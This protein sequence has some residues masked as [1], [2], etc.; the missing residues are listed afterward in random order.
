MKWM[1]LKPI[2]QGEESQNEKDKYHV[3]MHP[4]GIQKD[5]DEEP[6]CRAANET[7]T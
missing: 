2:A 7:Q 6:I 3:L 4:Y 5:D 1:N